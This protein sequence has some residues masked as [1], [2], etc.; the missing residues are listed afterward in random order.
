MGGSEGSK[1]SREVAKERRERL[2][3][4]AVR[5]RVAKRRAKR[6]LV[7]R[8]ERLSSDKAAL[9]SAEAAAAAVEAAG[10]R[11]SRA[12][13]R[14]L[15]Q[16]RDALQGRELRLV[17]HN[18]AVVRDVL[19]RKGELQA[20]FSAEGAL[21]G[22]E[23]L[24]FL[25]EH[26][27]LQ[28]ALEALSPPKSWQ[29][30]SGKTH[31]RR[32][33]FPPLVLNLLSV[34]SRYLGLRSGAQVQAGLLA[35]ERWMRLCGFSM[36]EVVEGVTTRSLGL[37][38]KTRNDERK[39]EDADEAGP[40]RARPRTVRGAL[41]SQTLAQW[42]QDLPRE[43]LVALFN[44]VV[45]ALVA[46]HFVG[47]KVRAVVDSTMLEVSPSFQGAG[48]VSRQVKVQSKARR[49]AKR[50]VMVRGFKLWV[51]M[52][53][54]S[55]LPLAFAL[56]TAEKPE[57]T[58]VRDLVAQARANLGGQGNLVSI[59]LDRGFM[60]GALLWSLAQDDGLEWIV[61]AKSSMRVH[62]EA[63]SRVYE[64]LDKHAQGKESRLDVARRLARRGRAV[65]HVS[66]AERRDDPGR[67]PLVVAEL[68]GLVDT[69]F[70][71]PGGARSSR[72][73]SKHFEPTPL[74]AT[75]VL[76]WPDRHHG[77]EDDDDTDA[78]ESR[79]L[80][81]LSSRPHPRMRRYRWYDDRSLIENSIFRD[82]KQHFALGVSLA[83][84]RASLEAASV[85]S[86]VALILERALRD[87]TERLPERGDRR[88]ERLGVV[89]YRRQLEARNRGKI[90]I[91]AADCYTVMPLS[92]F[93]TIAGF[94][95]RAGMF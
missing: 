15:A 47:K 79:P 84:N 44:A 31:E 50:K 71:G 72:T 16:W 60:D 95:G 38:G 22:D 86:L 87:H 29:D 68:A 10:G 70:Y 81:I 11:V 77:N 7:V 3:G 34:L 37:Q 59:I 66:F 48:T 33:M 49:P 4:D 53:A 64:V 82:G 88:A 94:L 62:E 69:D 36:M 58:H 25:L 17:E 67:A 65:N 74:H 56:D 5:R 35:D 55:R 40:V 73:N 61:P 42:E 26:L 27:E 83:R 30:D 45:Q 46:K 63:L 20:I 80:V 41:S 85:M 43:R 78:E 8:A 51:L 9:E 76:S 18:D 28:G 39:F 92:E 14:F 1:G 75:V 54:D 6:E 91:V 12:R 24:W 21:E 2:S 89:R 93:A 13:R 90:I 19:A 23:L 52:D 32:F 57:N